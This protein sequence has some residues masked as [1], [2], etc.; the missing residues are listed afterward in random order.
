MLSLISHFAKP[1]GLHYLFLNSLLG[2]IASFWDSLSLCCPSGPCDVQ[3]GA[4]ILL[5]DV[6]MGNVEN[7]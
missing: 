6:G 1:Q 3:E 7:A 5:L 4:N 2:E